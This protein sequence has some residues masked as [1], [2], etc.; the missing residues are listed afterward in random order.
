VSDPARPVDAGDGAMSPFPSGYGSL[1]SGQAGADEANETRPRAVAAPAKERK[2]LSESLA[3]R[4]S[5][6]KPKPSPLRR[7]RRADKAPSGSVPAVAA[8][9]PAPM[10]VTRSPSPELAEA[11]SARSGLEAGA[12]T[13]SGPG[14]TNGQ[15][16]APV[17]PTGRPLPAPRREPSLRDPEALVEPR[18]TVP[19]RGLPEAVAHQVGREY[20]PEGDVVVAR[21][22][23][24]R[25]R[26][27]VT[28]VRA[29]SSRRLVRRLDTWTVFKVSLIFY[30]LALVIVLVAGLVT[31]RVAI[32]VG[33]VND[34]QKAVRSLADDTKFVLHGRV[35]FKY[36][37]IGGAVLAVAGTLLNVVA[38]MLYNLI[39]DI[40]GGVQL[41]VVKEPD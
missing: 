13:R 26:R 39:S 3:E 38:A 23:W 5:E 41:V 11:S 4:R 35:V 25:L 33:F 21:H 9:G 20:S 8:A 37:A 27:K 36:T 6:R 14:H 10:P 40:F 7:R 1:D 19:R 24:W 31:W 12:P 18:R 34:I 32:Q 15:A 2:R 29:R 30:A 16:P 28:V 17:R 22:H